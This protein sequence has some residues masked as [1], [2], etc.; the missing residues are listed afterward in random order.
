P[1]LLIIV[2]EMDDGG[3]GEALADVAE[4][5]WSTSPRIFLEPDDLLM[6]VQTTSAV[7]D[8]P[9]HAGPAVRS[10]ML[11]PRV[12]LLEE[13]MFV[14]WPTAT[15]HL[16]EIAVERVGQPGSGLGPERLVLLGET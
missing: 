3:S 14:A 12:P 15:S 10:E 8:R 7:F 1:L 9:T 11:L 2:T 13:R 16:A 5:T 4:S 6:Q